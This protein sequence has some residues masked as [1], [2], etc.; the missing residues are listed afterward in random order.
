MPRGL[1]DRIVAKQV[2]V[3]SNFAQALP[4]AHGRQACQLACLHASIDVA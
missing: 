2:R 4:L 1:D 3:H